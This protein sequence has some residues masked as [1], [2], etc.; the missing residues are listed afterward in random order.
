MSLPSLDDDNDEMDL[1]ELDLDPSTLEDV[2]FQES[3]TAVELLRMNVVGLLGSSA[4][5]SN[6]SRPFD[7]WTHGIDIRLFNSIQRN[8]F[9]LYP[10]NHIDLCT[11]DGDHFPITLPRHCHDPLNPV[12]DSSNANVAFADCPF[13]FKAYTRQQVKSTKDGSTKAEMPSCAIPGGVVWELLPLGVEL[14]C[15]SHEELQDLILHRTQFS[16]TL[17]VAYLASRLSRWCSSIEGYT[18]FVTPVAVTGDAVVSDA[19]MWEHYLRNVLRAVDGSRS[20]D[21]KPVE[22]GSTALFGS[23]KH[24]SIEHLRVLLKFMA[25]PGSTN[26]GVNFALMSVYMVSMQFWLFVNNRFMVRNSS[27]PPTEYQPDFMFVLNLS[28]DLPDVAHRKHAQPSRLA[29][30]MDEMHQKLSTGVGSVELARSVTLLQFASV[31]LSHTSIVQLI[32]T[33][34]DGDRAHAV[35]E[36]GKFVRNYIE[37]NRLKVLQARGSIQHRSVS[38]INWINSQCSVATTSDQTNAPSIVSELK[39]HPSGSNAMIQLRD[40][41]ISKNG[42]VADLDTIVPFFFSHTFLTPIAPLFSL[43]DTYTGAQLVAEQEGEQLRLSLVKASNDQ[44]AQFARLDANHISTTSAHESSVGTLRKTVSIVPPIAS[45]SKQTTTKKKKAVGVSKKLKTSHVPFT[46]A[47]IEEQVACRMR[48]TTFVM[49]VLQFAS[50]IKATDLRHISGAIAHYYADRATNG[51]LLVHH[52]MYREQITPKGEIRVWIR[53]LPHHRTIRCLEDLP[54]EYEPRLPTWSSHRYACYI[55]NNGADAP[56]FVHRYVREYETIGSSFVPSVGDHHILAMSLLDWQLYIDA[57]GRQLGV[58]I[59]TDTSLFEHL[60]ERVL[61][62]ATDR[63]EQSVSV[64]ESRVY[65][66]MYCVDAWN[67]NCNPS[68]AGSNDGATYLYGLFVFLS[69]HIGGNDS[70]NLEFELIF[71]FIIFIYRRM[72]QRGTQLKSLFLDKRVATVVFTQLQASA[73]ASFLAAS[74]RAF[75]SNCIHPMQLDQAFEHWNNDHTQPVCVDSIKVSKM[76]I[77][78]GGAFAGGRIVPNMS[79]QIIFHQ[80]ACDPMHHAEFNVLCGSRAPISYTVECISSCI[81][82]LISTAMR[83]HDRTIALPCTTM[84]SW[85][86]VRITLASEMCQLY[87]QGRSF[88][89]MVDAVLGS[90]IPWDD[91]HSSVMTVK[92][93]QAVALGVLWFNCTVLDI[94]STFMDFQL[95]VC[96]VHTASSQH[97]MDDVKSVNPVRP[98]TK[99]HSALNVQVA[100]LALRVPEINRSMDAIDSS[101]DP[102]ALIEWVNAERA[103]VMCLLTWIDVQGLVGER[104]DAIR[105]LYTRMVKIA[106]D[107]ERVSSSSS[108]SVVAPVFVAPATVHLPRSSSTLPVVSTTASSSSSAT[109]STRKRPRVHSA[110]TTDVR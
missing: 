27:H 84:P 108:S 101:K 105:Q 46:C 55:I 34:F 107:H 41:C 93:Q 92:W 26:D 56:P 22:A 61:K 11:R 67:Y 43:D 68:A 79:H 51:N 39:Q 10:T 57:I 9:P 1:G 76:L 80:I 81:K 8:R 89:R 64:L 65:V 17:S 6:H 47:E 62:N 52:T 33:V 85:V 60:I 14:R 44:I 66:P 82:F 4:F 19:D 31:V 95:P 15:R 49:R 32:T 75:A 58:H 88:A 90:S 25:I 71:C 63:I 28:T 98:L 40:Q 77:P 29:L 94:V 103:S 74:K 45:D 35:S 59:E 109:T 7:H 16:T 73:N 99:L 3:H 78:M 23:S 38:L 18:N 86:S 97:W 30:S 20:G 13:R 2:L 53:T 24:H 110:V 37:L 21:L 104:T 87:K 102:L 100:E 91:C 48:A 36:I 69:H 50:F 106:D 70:Q 54:R 83:S 12:A 42:M 5:Q 96:L 72:N